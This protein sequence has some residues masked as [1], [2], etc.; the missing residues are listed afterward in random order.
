M[1]RE[2]ATHNPMLVVPM[3]VLIGF[4]VFFVAV[5]LYVA[6]RPA[7]RFASLA[8]LPLEE[9]S[10]HS[11]AVASQVSISRPIPSNPSKEHV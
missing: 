4:F 9:D 3:G 1:L 8:A 10:S 2:F 7:S 11:A 6:R 5:V